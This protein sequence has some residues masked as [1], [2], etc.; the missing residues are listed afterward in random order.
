MVKRIIFLFIVGLQFSFFTSS[1]D[2]AEVKPTIPKTA[3]VIATPEALMTLYKE[4][5]PETTIEES[6]LRYYS[7]TILEEYRKPELAIFRWCICNNAGEM[8][9]LLLILEVT[10]HAIIKNPPEITPQLVITSIGSGGLKQEILLGKVLQREG[11]K[12][13]H[14]NLI[15]PAYF[16]ESTKEYAQKLF[17]ALKMQIPEATLSEF[18]YTTDYLQ[19]LVE[20]KRELR[21][22]YLLCVDFVNNSIES[23]N[24]AIY[25]TAKNKKNINIWL[26]IL[27]YQFTPS[28]NPRRVESNARA[29]FL[30]NQNK[31]LETYYATYT[32]MQES[33]S[34]IDKLSYAKQ[35]IEETVILGEELTSFEVTPICIPHILLEETGIYSLRKENPSLAFLLQ[36]NKIL[37]TDPTLIEG[38]FGGETKTSSMQP[39][40][41]L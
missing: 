27:Q 26:F 35:Q 10:L 4:T 14:F 20:D 29:S 22:H 19:A 25:I 30:Y 8:Q 17:S 6:R 37:W 13:L 21:T 39:L 16:K 38:S 9:R 3:T 28:L 5:H 36:A 11:Y 18:K 41:Q 12:T 32:K 23:Q 1:I 40:S 33:R 7:T 24:N 31:V 2:A 15:D 34:Q